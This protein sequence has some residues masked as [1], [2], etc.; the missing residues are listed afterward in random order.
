VLME[1]CCCSLMMRGVLVC[2]QSWYSM[3]KIRARG[4]ARAGLGL[5]VLFQSLLLYGGLAGA[6]NGCMRAVLTWP[7]APK[8]H[9]QGAFKDTTVYDQDYSWPSTSEVVEV[10]TP[11]AHPH[12]RVP[13]GM[14]APSGGYRHTSSPPTPTDLKHLRA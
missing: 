6:D 5:A 13:L 11:L 9:P 7:L 10:R 2:I 12:S 4:W 14:L 3:I 1:S 8:R